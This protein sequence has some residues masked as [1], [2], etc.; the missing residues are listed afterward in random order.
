M[1]FVRDQLLDGTKIGALII[2]DVLSR[3]SICRRLT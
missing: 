3:V 1:D 2:V